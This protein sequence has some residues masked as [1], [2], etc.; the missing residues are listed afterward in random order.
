MKRIKLVVT[1]DVEHQCLHESLRRFFPQNREREA[2]E[3]LAPQKTGSITSS[4]LAPNGVL[5]SPAR[6]MAAALV[7]AVMRSDVPHQP[8]PDLVIGVDDLELGN[9]GQGAVVVDHLRRAVE[10]ELT[11]LAPQVRPDVR[12]LLNERCS[13]H[14]LDPMIEAYFFAEPAALT[15]A[16]AN[17]PASVAR[18]NVEDFES[19][20]PAWL[21]TCRE[22]NLRRHH[23]GYHW[24]RHERH[25]KA[26]LQHLVG[27]GGGLYQETRGGRAALE[28]FDWA[29]ANVDAASVPYARSLFRD[30]AEW[31]GVEPPLGHE[32]TAPATYPPG[33]T[34]RAE[35]LL[36][37]L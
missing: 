18:P 7:A 16:G 6:R 8:A 2:V 5:S 25:P 28:R 4:R 29:L 14:L 10:A 13:F 11:T 23:A 32:A 24:W 15:R 37:N 20:D 30:L 1:G 17:A 12:S 26:Y 3:W 33:H 31:F 34:K 21:P 19:T 9:Q 27:L 22:E 35:L 36:R